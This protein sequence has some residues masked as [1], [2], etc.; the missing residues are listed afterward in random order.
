MQKY[1][2]TAEELKAII[3]LYQ[4]FNPFMTTNRIYSRWKLGKINLLS[5]YLLWSKER[6]DE[7]VKEMK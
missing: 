2:L 5:D 1:E 7:L 4:L 6:F 3:R